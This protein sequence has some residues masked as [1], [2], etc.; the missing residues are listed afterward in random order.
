MTPNGDGENDTWVIEN[1]SSYPNNEL[2]I[3]DRTGKIIYTKK[4][5]ANDWNGQYNGTDIPAGTYF[6]ILTFDDGKRSKK[7]F[8]SIVK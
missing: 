7:G 8:I 1:L 5:Y 6:Y 3:M 2:K 4:D